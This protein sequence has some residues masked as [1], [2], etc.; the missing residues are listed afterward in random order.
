MLGIVAATV[1][2]QVLYELF[3]VPRPSGVARVPLYWWL[4]IAAPAIIAALVCGWFTMSW[5]EGLAAAALAAIALQLGVQ[6]AATSGRPGWHK[7]WGIEAPL[8][9][10]TGG[11]LSAF[12]LLSAVVMLG[13][14]T[15][16]A[17]RQRKP[18]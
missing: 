8:Y 12:F 17:L 11:V 1:A 13:R 2:S 10:W 7:S 16:A 15:N 9:H 3:V 6:V 18:S 5:R 14:I 4:G